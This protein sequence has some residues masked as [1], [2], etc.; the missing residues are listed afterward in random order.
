MLKLNICVKDFSFLEL[1]LILGFSRDFPL[2]G[3]YSG[4][5]L[6]FSHGGCGSHPPKLFAIVGLQLLFFCVLVFVPVMTVW[7]IVPGSILYVF[8]VY[9]PVM[10]SC[11]V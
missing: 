11:Y 1:V 4:F 3:F 5:T 10:S 8:I 2:L 9:I 7:S 6:V